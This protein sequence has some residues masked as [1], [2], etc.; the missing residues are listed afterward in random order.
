MHA[1]SQSQLLHPSAGPPWSWRGVCHQY[2]A[3]NGTCTQLHKS[4]WSETAASGRPR[5]KQ[6]AAWRHALRGPM[7][8]WPP[9]ACTPSLFLFCLLSCTDRAQSITDCLSHCGKMKIQTGQSNA[10]YVYQSVTKYSEFDWSVSFF[11]FSMVRQATWNR[12]SLYTMRL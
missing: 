2:Q 6:Q 12:Y 8:P 4:E 5:G 3:H 10:S 7:E 1:Q 11:V 9:S